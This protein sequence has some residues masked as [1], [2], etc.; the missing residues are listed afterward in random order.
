VGDRLAERQW[1][2]SFQH[3][4]GE[5]HLAE[6]RHLGREERGRDFAVEVVI[7]QEEAM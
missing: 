1:H 7:V 2:V 6:A 3:V 5:I 4:A